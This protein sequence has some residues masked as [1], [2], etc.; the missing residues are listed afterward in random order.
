MKTFFFRF[1][2]L[3]ILGLLNMFLQSWYYWNNSTR[4]KERHLYLWLG[5]RYRREPRNSGLWGVLLLLQDDVNSQG[6][7]PPH[8]H[9]QQ[10]QGSLGHRWLG[11]VPQHGAKGKWSFPHEFKMFCHTQTVSKLT[12]WSHCHFSHL[13]VFP[14][15]LSVRDK[16]KTPGSCN[17]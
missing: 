10:P 8:A 1:I 15:W 16:T 3:G 5:G 2:I 7:V 12:I 9:L 14:K 17:Q 6:F 13:E 11:P 4:W